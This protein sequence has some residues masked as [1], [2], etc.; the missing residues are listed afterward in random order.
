MSAATPIYVVITDFDGWD[1]TQI[2][3]RDLQR[4]SYKNLKVIV[5]DHGLTDETA[6][7]LKDFPSCTRIAA[8]STLWWTGATNIGI[9]SALEQG[10]QY[11]MLL[12]NDCYVAADTVARLIDLFDETTLQVIAPLQISAH[13]GEVL[14][15]RITT[16]FTLGFPTVALPGKTSLL[17]D[18]SG[19]VATNLIIG[20]RGVVVPRAVFSAVGLFDEA[21]LP[22]YGADHD[23][24]LRCRQAGIPM[25]IAPAATVAMDE[26]RTT[27]S[28]NLGSMTLGEFFRSF[29]DPRS[30]RN[31]S[32]LRTLFSRYYPI[33]GLYLVGVALN[34]LRYC[35]SYLLQ[36]VKFRFAMIGGAKD[37]Q[38]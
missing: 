4:S 28:R 17:G 27:V 31:L 35:L 13:T 7:G 11:I 26:T 24:Y 1:Q 36:R 19:L 15:G 6:R 12:N 16:C 23:F 18:L 32:V 22:H 25:A 3:L 20:G 9:R 34:V 2:C 5:V 33:K 29:K 37:L 30:H 38:Q 14:A 10:A 21:N 8:E